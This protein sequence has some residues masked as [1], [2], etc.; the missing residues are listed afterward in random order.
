MI[1]SR[2]VKKYQYK[3]FNFVINFMQSIVKIVNRFSF[4]SIEIQIVI[5]K[6]LFNDVKNSKI[7]CRF[8]EN[9]R[10]RRDYVE[11]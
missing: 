4:L 1:K 11:I 10:V 3:Y 6:L 8:E 2:R 9:I 7:S 5:L